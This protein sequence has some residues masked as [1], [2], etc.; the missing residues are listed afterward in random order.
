MLTALEKRSHTR[1]LIPALDFTTTLV[2]LAEVHPPTYVLLGG[3]QKVEL[4]PASQGDCKRTVL[5]LSYGRIR[6]ASSLV[7]VS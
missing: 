2:D 4:P 6:A 1:P 5:L 3:G 7:R